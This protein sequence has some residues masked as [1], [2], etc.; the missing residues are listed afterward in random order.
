MPSESGASIFQRWKRNLV[1]INNESSEG[2]DDITHTG[3]SRTESP[4]RLAPGSHFSQPTRPPLGAEGDRKPR[5]RAAGLVPGTREEGGPLEKEEEE[6]GGSEGARS[7]G[8]RRERRSTE[9]GREE[10]ARE[11]R[12]R[13]VA[14][15]AS[16]VEMTVS[17]R[18]GAS[19]RR[20]GAAATERGHGTG[21]EGEA[22]ARKE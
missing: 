1:K 14:P 17:V 9:R 16:K 19:G 21:T 20:P 22:W 5:L 11:H 15:L 4:E 2:Q 6:R 7:E 10:G 12:A 3:Q 18:V 13:A 8:E